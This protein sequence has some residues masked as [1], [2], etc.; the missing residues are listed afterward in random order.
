[1]SFVVLTTRRHA[2]R[3]TQILRTA[4][5]LVRW[6]WHEAFDTSVPIVFSVGSEFAHEPPGVPAR[7]SSNMW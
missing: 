3:P 1:M 5:T 6:L 4:L 2:G 7:V